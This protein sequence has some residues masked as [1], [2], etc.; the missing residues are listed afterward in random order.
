MAKITV[1]L[2]A[3]V[4]ATHAAS[5]R[6]ASGLRPHEP[7]RLA[8]AVNQNSKAGAG[9]SS[10]TT[11]TIDGVEYLR[12]YSFTVPA[13]Y[14]CAEFPTQTMTLW[15]ATDKVYGFCCGEACDHMNVPPAFPGKWRGVS[16][17]KSTIQT[18]GQWGVSFHGVER[19]CKANGK[20]CPDIN[21]FCGGKYG[22][23][24]K[25]CCTEVNAVVNKEKKALGTTCKK[26]AIA[27]FGTYYAACNEYGDPLD[28]S[29]LCSGYGQP[30][31]SIQACC[32]KT[33]KF[34]FRF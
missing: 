22:E 11:C 1:I 17:V 33:V 7:T 3:L 31:C 25:V 30:A 19:V 27:N 32:E 28:Y 21:T 13:K 5:S 14:K 12:G 2:A 20:T 16:E 9:G 15:C 29:N 6:S 4:V 8:S 18:C 26:W 23:C 10:K 34:N 24:D